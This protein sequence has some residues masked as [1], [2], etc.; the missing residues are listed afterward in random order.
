VGS[1]ESVG[2]TVGVAEGIGVAEGTAVGMAVGSGPAL[3]VTT[4]EA[5]F[6]PKGDWKSSTIRMLR[7]ART[8]RAM[9]MLK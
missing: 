2:G 9:A 3:G 6:G 8:A 5:R 4:L 1:D 7:A